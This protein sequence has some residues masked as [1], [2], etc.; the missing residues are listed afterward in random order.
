MSP[1]SRVTPK[2]HRVPIRL[3]VAA[4]VSL[5][6]ACD[7]S[8][9]KPRPQPSAKTAASA[10]ASAS[11]TAEPTF[12]KLVKVE[13]FQTPE[14]IRYDPDSDLYLVANINGAP[15]AM[16]GNGFISRVKPDGTIAE[17]QWIDGTKDGVTLSAP[18]GMALSGGVLYVADVTHLR[19]FDQKT[20]APK[21]EI[22]IAGATFLN[23]VATGP[24]GTVYVSD[25]GLQ[26]GEKG[27]EP[28]GTDAVYRIDAEAGTAKAIAK[29]K[30]LDRPNGLFV[31]EAGVWVV[32]FGAGELYRIGSD[33]KRA[34]LHKLPAGSLDGI[35]GLPDGR[36]LISSWATKTVYRGPKHGPFKPL[37]E[38]VSAPADIGYDTKRNRLLIPRFNDH[39]IELR[40]LDAP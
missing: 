7:D 34:D 13:G 6:G 17:L 40:I 29:G 23:D 21:G 1:S 33:G 8:K 25:S 35:V 15:L 24:D 11:P 5:S 37:V 4:L 27:F 30:E 22:E 26:Q 10:T 3:A 20:G 9:S 36:L 28:S 19:K 2:V 18:K 14:S 16:D 12:P 38:R 32:T 31:D 39:I